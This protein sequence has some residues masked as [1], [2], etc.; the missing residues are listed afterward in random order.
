VNTRGESQYSVNAESKVVVARLARWHAPL[1]LSMAPL[2]MA[3]A[4]IPNVIVDLQSGSHG[5][6]YLIKLFLVKLSA[7][8]LWLLILKFAQI[9]IIR[10]KTK[11]INLFALGFLGSVIGAI[12]GTYVHY[13]SL[14]IGLPV[15][16]TTFFRRVFSTALIGFSWLPVTVVLSSSFNR[17]KVMTSVLESSDNS[18]LRQNFRVSGFYKSYVVKLNTDISKRLFSITNNLSKDISKLAPDSQ[19]AV[20]HVEEIIKVI[21]TKD[22]RDFSNELENK[23]SLPKKNSLKFKV[24]RLLTFFSLTIEAIYVSFK[25]SPLNPRIFTYIVTIC[26]FGIAIRRNQNPIATLEY[27]ILIGSLTFMLTFAIWFA[28]K[29]RVKYYVFVAILF[30]LINIYAPATITHYFDNR[31]YEFAKIGSGQNFTLLWG[32]L[33][34]ACLLLGHIGNASINAERNLFNFRKF[35]KL[36]SEIEGDMIKDQENLINHK[37]AVHIHGKIQ[38][39]LSTTVLA[40]RQALASSDNEGVLKALG[41]L[42]S[43]LQEPTAGFT[44]VQR[45]IE[46]EVSE[47]LT[48]WDGLLDSDIIIDPLLIKSRNI[49]T[50]LIGEVIEEIISNS[51]RHGAASEIRIE[52]RKIGSKK[53]LIRTEDN[54]VNLPPSAGVKGKGGVGTSIFN[55]ASDGRWSLKRDEKRAKTVFEMRM[56]TINTSI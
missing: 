17:F 41:S 25:N 45:D 20:Q 54:A 52:I 36:L 31:G 26:T 10:S 18:K 28:W 37:W 12:T 6:G 3:L 43:V 11:A 38:T 13:I 24:S 47:R 33:I 44:Q 34:I 9:A 27:G 7:L 56:D 30:T 48:P 39:R 40:L 16:S 1:D 19:S 22:L 55:A 46:S 49:P 42:Q 50:Q 35:N 5:H 51:V 8:L 29:L 21:E 2:F 4:L 15:D 53:I 23:I 14:S 32:S